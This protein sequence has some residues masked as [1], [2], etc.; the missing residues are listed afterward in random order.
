MK[1]TRRELNILIENYLETE[2]ALNEVQIG[3]FKVAEVE[4]CDFE[5]DSEFLEYFTIMFTGKGR[6]PYSYR[7]SGYA[8]DELP[9]WVSPAFIKMFTDAAG[10][11]LN[12][13]GLIPVF[14]QKGKCDLLQKIQDIFIKYKDEYAKGIP[15]NK[16]DEEPC[17]TGQVRNSSGICVNSG[18][19]DVRLETEDETT[20]EGL[21]EIPRMIEILRRR[22]GIDP[23]ASSGSAYLGSSELPGITAEETILATI[24]LGSLDDI[25]I[26]RASKVLSNLE[27][28]KRKR[29]VSAE[30]IVRASSDLDDSQKEFLQRILS[31]REMPD[32]RKAIVM[33]MI[34]VIKKLESARIFK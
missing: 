28:L 26:V 23:P 17:P 20:I 34:S 11:L 5:P 24:I 15:L 2:S 7:R 10:P 6:D 3:G 14:N 9:T 18:D 1:I 32:D 16:E 12:A 4:R 30:D 19:I 13:Y 8:D 31:I 27:S 21:D 25:P 33:A 22:Y 29:L